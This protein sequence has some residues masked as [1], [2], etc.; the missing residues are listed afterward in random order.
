MNVIVISGKAQ[1]GKTTATTY[2]SSR[3]DKSVELM[4]AK[5]L[6]DYA[7]TLLNWNGS[8]ETKPRTFL[9]DI[10][11]YIRFEL[12]KPDLLINRTIE[13]IQA[14]AKYCDTFFISDCRFK[15]ELKLLREVFASELITIRIERQGFENNLTETQKQHITEVDLDDYVGFDYVIRPTTKESLY[16]ELDVVVKRIGG[17]Q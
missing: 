16:G 2:L 14:M 8:E 4:I 12:N 1:N 15:N 7:R 5:P 11:N 6:K 9:Q 3:L 10:G 17:K 13:D